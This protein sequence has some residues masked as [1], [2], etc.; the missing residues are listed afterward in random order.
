[1]FGSILSP[2]AK[3]MIAIQTP[4][5]KV[6]TLDPESGLCIGCGRTGGE[7]ASWSAYSERERARIMALLPGRL[8]RSRA[9]ADAANG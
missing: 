9:S 2:A 3:P 7:I 6:C 4:C 5:T 1:M 8:A